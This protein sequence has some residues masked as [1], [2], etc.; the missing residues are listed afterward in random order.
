MSTMP[1]HTSTKAM[2]MEFSI[3]VVVVIEF[4]EK[5]VLLN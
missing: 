3:S 4:T 5:T 2:L 1:V